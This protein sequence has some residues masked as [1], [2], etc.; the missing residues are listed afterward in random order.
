MRMRNI[1]QHRCKPEQ[2]RGTAEYGLIEMNRR[3]AAFVV[4]LFLLIP[5]FAA[6]YYQ[7]ESSQLEHEAF[8][9]LDNIVQV[10]SNQIRRW[11]ME[12]NGDSLIFRQSQNI[13]E[14]VEKLIQ[15]PGNPEHRNI[16]KSRLA[17]MLTAYDYE[18][19]M[20]IDSKRKLLLTT[21]QTTEIPKKLDDLLKQVL[22]NGS[23]AHS[24]FYLS[25][26][27]NIYMDW[28]VPIA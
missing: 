5:L 7:T 12:R 17:L 23:I 9:N 15:E 16:L 6:L 21:D 8:Q 2:G 25:S 18:A 28:V 13:R 24:D 11:M 22:A 27:G 10:K 20:L 14:R 1:R 19:A 4:V 3:L 26:A